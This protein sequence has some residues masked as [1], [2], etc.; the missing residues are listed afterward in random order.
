[1]NFN[2]QQVFKNN[3]EKKLKLELEENNSNNG[4]IKENKIKT[5]DNQ[6]KYD[7]NY[8]NN[9][10]INQNSIDIVGEDK[11]EGKDGGIIVEKL[12]K[13]IGKIM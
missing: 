3:E 9:I 4:R 2:K 5:S 13:I 6:N 12:I 7:S 1:M 11:K 10:N 8:I